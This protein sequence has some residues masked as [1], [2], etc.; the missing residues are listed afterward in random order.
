M[1]PLNMIN[2]LVYQIFNL[3]N[4]IQWNN[5]NRV[6]I[7]KAVCSMSNE[8]F[9]LTVRRLH[10]LQKFSTREALFT[11]SKMG[12]KIPSKRGLLWL[13][14]VAY[15]CSGGSWLE[16]DQRPPKAHRNRSPEHMCAGFPCWC[17]RCDCCK[18]RWLAG[19]TPGVYRDGWSQTD[20]ND[21]RQVNP[22]W[23]VSYFVL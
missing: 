15:L 14:L 9:C 3:I 2:S 20:S 5:L 12:L 21:R 8:K 17:P 16:G 1:I 18:G 22:T 23:N 10:W 6:V 19:D 7:G 11:A 13:V 4:Q